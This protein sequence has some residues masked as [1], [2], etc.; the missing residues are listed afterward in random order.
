MRR[1]P[2]LAA[3]PAVWQFLT[4]EALAS[5]MRWAAAPRLS[6]R[7]RPSSGV[8][9]DRGIGRISALFRALLITTGDPP[10]ISLQSHH[11]D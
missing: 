9:A 11:Y 1:F 2:T 8:D 4:P 3:T 10:K 7:P 6:G 5:R